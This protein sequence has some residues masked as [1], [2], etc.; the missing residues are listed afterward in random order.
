MRVREKET[1]AKREV[2]RTTRKKNLIEK[3]G[4]RK[5]S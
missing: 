5:Y 1:T 3:K 4:K 2:G